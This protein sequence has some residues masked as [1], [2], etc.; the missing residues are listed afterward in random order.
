M[1]PI[2]IICACLNREPARFLGYVML[3]PNVAEQHYSWVK[4]NVAAVGYS[5]SKLATNEEGLEDEDRSRRVSF[6]VITNAE[7][8]IRKILGAS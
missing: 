1:K 7:E 8:Q 2:S 5:S 6:R 3:L 4:A